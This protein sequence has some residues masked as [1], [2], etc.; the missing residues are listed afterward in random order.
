M[1]INLKQLF[2]NIGETIQV[3]TCIDISELEQWGSKP[4]KEPVQIKGTIANKTGIV[5]FT[6][7]ATYYIQSEC[8]RCLE[9]V[10]IPKNRKFEHI[11][12]ESL[13]E[14]SN[15]SYIVLDDAILDVNELVASDITLTLPFK[16][17]CNDDCKGIC[18]ECGKNLNTQECNCHTE[19]WADLRVKDA[20][21]KLFE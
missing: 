5:M 13:N 17:L 4:L 16:V 8:G 7:L 2:E 11:I 20:F 6:Y 18:P 10:K 12:V 21:G 9:D 14:A 1:K 15:D 3:D 19:E